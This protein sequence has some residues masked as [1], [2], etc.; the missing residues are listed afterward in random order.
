MLTGA[1]ITAA[2]ALP[3]HSALLNIMLTPPDS[4][5]NL[6]TI[7]LHLYDRL[8]LTRNAA[9]K[10]IMRCTVPEC[11]RE[12]K[13]W[14]ER[15][16]V[17]S[18]N[19]NKVPIV[20]VEEQ[21]A[22]R[23]PTAATHAAFYEAYGELGGFEGEEGKRELLRRV[24]HHAQR[25]EAARRTLPPA[26]T[27]GEELGNMSLPH[28]IVA[29]PERCIICLLHAEMRIGEKLLSMLMTMGIQQ[30]PELQ[31]KQRKD[32]HTMLEKAVNII[33][34]NLTPEEAA[35]GRTVPSNVRLPDSSPGQHI[36]VRFTCV[37]IQRLFQRHEQLINAVFDPNSSAEQNARWMLLFR[38]FNFVFSELRT[39]R[40]FTSEDTQK[41]QLTIDDFCRHYVTMFGGH[42]ITN[43]VH[44]MQAGH[45]SYFLQQHKNLYV[46]ANIGLEGTVKTTTSYINKGTQ[47][48][49]HGGAKGEKFSTVAA[50]SRHLTNKA[51]YTLGKV[52]GDVVNFITE[53]ERKGK[54]IKKQ[55]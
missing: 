12:V 34:S 29:D 53:I 44:D 52:G 30:R 48:G 11:Q 25:L 26:P 2:E 21:L 39:Y 31:A 4:T 15:N 41:I 42:A 20:V 14:Y 16:D 33:I 46:H 18:V 7:R 55:T 19:I 24:L 1:D 17:N 10:D 47:R 51:V 54:A 9:G 22:R 6:Q 50:M 43:Y 23:L 36:Q 38:Q 32:V 37:R 27:D 13:G 35:D 8:L 40:P 5:A 45:F 28:R 49:G 3:P